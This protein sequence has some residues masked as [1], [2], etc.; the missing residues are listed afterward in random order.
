MFSVA[1]CRSALHHFELRILYKFLFFVNT[2]MFFSKLTSRCVTAATRQCRVVVA[3]S[4]V[5]HRLLHDGKNATDCGT[6]K[7]P[8]ANE[9]FLNKPRRESVRNILQSKPSNQ[10]YQI[11]VSNLLDCCMHYKI[12]WLLQGW[13]RLVQKTKL[14]TFA[15]L[16]DGSGATRLQLVIPNTLLQKYVFVTRVQILL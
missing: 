1:C 15:H 16:D 7:V 2:T 12:L 9:N 10:L 11:T 14:T 6:K 3:V 4:A 13:V 5:H 8:N